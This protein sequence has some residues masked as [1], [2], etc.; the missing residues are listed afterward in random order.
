MMHKL[1]LNNHHPQGWRLFFF[2]ILVMCCISQEMMAHQTPSTIVL[3]DVNPKTV[4]VELQ[5]PLGELELAFGHEITKDP[6]HLIQNFGPQLKEYLLAHIH[7]MT[8]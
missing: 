7:P 6:E 4:S 8:A 2:L 5:L 1:I 3:L